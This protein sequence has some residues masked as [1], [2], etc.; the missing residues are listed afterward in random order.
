MIIC[1]PSRQRDFDT[2]EY[3]YWCGELKDRHQYHRKQ[4]EFVTILEVLEDKLKPGT[5]ALGFGVGTEPLTSYFASK[6]IKVTAT[7]QA[8][9][10][11]EKRRWGNLIADSKESLYFPHIV[12]RDLF[13]KNVCYEHID[14]NYIP[15]DRNGKYDFIWSACSLEHLGCLQT[16]LWFIM[17]SLRLLKPGGISVHTTEYNVDSNDATN[18]VHLNAIYRRQDI[19]R[20]YQTVNN[21]GNYRM[22]DIDFDSGD[23]PYDKFIA[24]GHNSQPPHIK[25][26]IDEYNATSYVIIIERSI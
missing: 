8:P 3:H 23:L 5:T 4:W 17:D 19:E 10:K 25:L 9:T 12:Q 14:M 26:K 11:S 2:P 1:H 18:I 7:D 15:T 16:G 22:R 20:L 13:D 24:L 6:G 21:T